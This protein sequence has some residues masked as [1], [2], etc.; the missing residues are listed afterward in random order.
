MVGWSERLDVAI[1]G[2]A[3]TEWR[4]SSAMDGA[5]VHYR[6]AAEHVGDG[7]GVTEA[8]SHLRV[9]AAELGRLHGWVGGGCAGRAVA[10]TTA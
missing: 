10:L 6:G 4:P 3:V 1:G 7:A 5:G 9:L 2:G 8:L